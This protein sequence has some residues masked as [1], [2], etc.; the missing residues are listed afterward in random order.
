[1][2]FLQINEQKVIF[3]PGI[4]VLDSDRRE[5]VVGSGGASEQFLSDSSKKVETMNL[6]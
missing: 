6:D 1:M 3:V 5:E 4:H 2:S